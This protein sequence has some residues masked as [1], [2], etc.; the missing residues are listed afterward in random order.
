MRNQE[1]T[2]DRDHREAAADGLGD[3]VELPVIE[4]VPGRRQRDGLGHELGNG[5][6][7]G[8]CRLRRRLA[9]DDGGGRR[10]LELLLALRDASLFSGPFRCF[11]RRRFGIAVV[12]GGFDGLLQLPPLL[13]LSRVDPQKRADEGV[14]QRQD[15]HGGRFVGHPPDGLRSGHQE[16]DSE[17]RVHRVGEGHGE[18]LGHPRDLAHRVGVPPQEPPLLLPAPSDEA[19]PV[20]LPHQPPSEKVQGDEKGD[21]TELREYLLRRQRPLEFVGSDETA[22]GRGEAR[23]QARPAV[24]RKEPP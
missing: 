21:Q 3:G 24:L 10:P 2:H 11:R 16:P 14:V 17:A 12:G 8:R 19:G 1:P 15:G 23:L 22:G 7:I 4:P 18:D 9:R 6:G 5:G 13:P 20:G